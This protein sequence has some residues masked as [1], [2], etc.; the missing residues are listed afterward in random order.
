MRFVKQRRGILSRTSICL[1]MKASWY[2]GTVAH[3]CRVAR[4]CSTRPHRIGIEQSFAVAAILT[5]QGWRV[6]ILM[7]LQASVRRFHGS[8]HRL[9]GPL[10]DFRIAARTVTERFELQTS[11]LRARCP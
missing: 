10:P 1:A 7:V 11:P 6:G 2:K 8:H 3:P 5:Q 4:L 9:E